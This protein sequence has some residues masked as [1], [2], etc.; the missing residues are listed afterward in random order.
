MKNLLLKFL[1]LL[2]L[3]FS[4]PLFSQT[5]AIKSDDFVERIGFNTHFNMLA[6]P[7]VK[8]FDSVV[9]KLN[10]LGIRYIRSLAD[11]SSKI[12]YDRYGIKSLAGIIDV[13]EMDSGM[14][15]PMLNEIKQQLGTQMF[16]GFEGVNEPDQFAAAGW[17]EK[18]RQTQEALYKK[19]KSDPDWNHVKV[20]G[21]SN[22]GS[23]YSETGNMEAFSDI[24]NI[25][26][27]HAYPGNEAFYNLI[28]GYVFNNNY[29][30]GGP[31]TMT[32]TGFSQDEHSEAEVAKYEPRMFMYY[33]YKKN[34]NKVFQYEFIDELDNPSH[35]A[36]YGILRNDCSE[37]PAY[38]ALQNTIKLLTE[39][40]ANFAPDTLS[41]KLE[42]NLTN[43][44]H[45][46][47]Q[48]SNGIF[49]LAVWQEITGKND[50]VNPDRN[51]TLTI[52]SYIKTVKCYQPAPWPI[53]NG[54]TPYKAF[55]DQYS[56]ALNVPDQLMM[57]ELIPET[58][59]PVSV[60]GIT[61]MPLLTLVKGKNKQLNYEIQPVEATNKTVTWLSADNTIATVYNGVVT[62]LKAGTVKI[63]AITEDGSFEAN[64][65]LT[66]IEIPVS[67]VVV[68]PTS[69][70]LD[71]ID[72][73]TAKLTY[74]ILPLDAFNKN[75]EWK[76]GD[77]TIASVDENGLVTAKSTGNTTITATSVDGKK[78]GVCNVTVKGNA[79]E[80][81]T[82][83]LEVTADWNYF[84]TFVSYN[85][86]SWDTIKY[87][88][89]GITSNGFTLHGGGWFES[90][91]PG[92][93]AQYTFAGMAIKFFSIKRG[94]G[95]TGK[96]FLDNEFKK[97]I[98]FDGV[99]DTNLMFEWDFKTLTLDS[100][101]LNY[102]ADTL[103]IK[104]SIQLKLSFFP[105]N[106]PIQS[107]T[108]KSE[109]RVFAIITTDGLVIGKKKGETR[110]S[111]TVETL[112]GTKIA[113]C[114]IV[115]QE[116]SSVANLHSNDESFSVFPDPV[117]ANGKLNI[118]LKNIKSDKQLVVS[119]F[120]TLGI[121]VYTK[122]IETSNI[123]ELLLG[124]AIKPGFYVICIDGK[125]T[126]LSKKMTII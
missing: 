28:Y 74:S 119:I 58:V 15:A 110:V 59:I 19:I 86:A 95:G 97:D 88:N 14:V 101:K 84:G 21:P 66:V 32:E 114:T 1:I 92:A 29:P 104:D 126:R 34:M 113:Y 125:Q 30:N 11:E 102:T 3:C 76:S 85:G 41:Y 77:T 33:L 6:T 72:N 37:K 17:P 53:G 40:G 26:Y 80:T 81:H 99:G 98:S 103:N 63:S 75:V 121:K 93:Y 31:I 22:G 62:A 120:N 52:P 109:N 87:N 70:I 35:E 38:S 94:W 24:G 27:Y 16:Y 122:S 57:V 18:T 108:W 60:S 9:Y 123:I 116:P 61:T 45:V 124:E 112:S 43:I 68:S 79:S 89:P 12:V 67:A 117:A 50:I 106:A 91:S 69:L 64:T 39:K 55:T 47:F 65:T 107:V 71:T 8:N 118:L 56:I 20:L 73:K 51:L 90:N 4:K 5:T 46:L 7:Y 23:G 42:G 105:A 96:I 10:E 111:A 44:H 2:T 54:L 100:I 82:I 25:H 13:S 83:K 78:T 49:Y 48:K 115:V 36:N